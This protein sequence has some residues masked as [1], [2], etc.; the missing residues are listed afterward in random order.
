MKNLNKKLSEAKEKF[1]E[2][3]DTSY[4]TSCEN[5]EIAS[6]TAEPKNNNI[7]TLTFLV[8][9]I[10]TWVFYYH[11]SWFKCFLNI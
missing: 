6:L 1:S 9:S 8:L 11:V 2:L 4:D 7:H 10:D 3:K 5:L